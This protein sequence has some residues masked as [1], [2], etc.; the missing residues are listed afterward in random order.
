MSN[1]KMVMVPVEWL[2]I[3]QE[4][5]KR[6]ALTSVPLKVEFMRERGMATLDCLHDWMSNTRNAFK[7]MIAAAPNAEPQ[8]AQ[9]VRLPDR[10]VDTLWQAAGLT[11]YH[12][13]G[14]QLDKFYDF[15]DR[16][17]KEVLARLPTALSQ[18]AEAEQAQDATEREFPQRPTLPPHNA[19]CPL[20]FIEWALEMER[21]AR[22]SISAAQ[23]GSEVDRLLGALAEI[24]DMFP[25]PDPGSDLEQ[26]WS[27]AIGCPEEVPGY[28]KACLDAAQPADQTPQDDHRG[29]YCA[30]CQRGVDGSEVTFREQH[31]VCGRVITDDRP[32][33]QQVVAVQPAGGER[34][35]ASIAAALKKTYLQSVC[36]DAEKALLV[37]A[38]DDFLTALQSKAEQ[39]AEGEK[40]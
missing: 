4:E 18:P 32:P 40:K 25:V 13:G 22:A 2:H 9:D 8:Q 33:S 34:D 26:I 17:T 21:I 10:V 3:C 7:E 15:S 6:G 37:A 23:P 29:W 16:V 39:T 14:S 24:R 38:V 30:H 12:P 1:E 19:P 20:E 27:G 36:T 35:A 11:S 31:T 28:V 5:F